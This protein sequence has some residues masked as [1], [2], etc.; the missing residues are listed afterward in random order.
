MVEYLTWAFNQGMTEVDFLCGEEQYK[1]KFA[2]TQTDLVSYVGART[3]VGSIALAVGER[4]D[5]TRQPGKPAELVLPGKL[6]G[7]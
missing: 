2:T 1:F 6:A 7:A 5:K 3:W 4:L